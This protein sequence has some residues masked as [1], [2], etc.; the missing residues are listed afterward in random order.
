VTVRT[1]PSDPIEEALR[2]LTDR[3]PGGVLTRRSSL[4]AEARAGLQDASEA[5]RAAGLPERQAAERAVAEFGDPDALWADYAAQVEAGFVRRT[6]LLLGVGYLV[7]LFAWQITGQHA[8]DAMPRGS[9]AAS[10]SFG[11][12]GALAVLTMATAL[13]WLRARARRCDQAAGR[14]ARV[15][16]AAGLVCAVATLIAS[17]LVEPWGDRR[18]ADAASSVVHR[19]ELLVST[20]ELFSGALTFAIIWCSLN[21]LRLSRSVRAANRG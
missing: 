8:E 4:L 17:Y 12:I 3:L 16:G 1:A 20:V 7:I 9:V 11:Y 19:P 18:G 13:L 6:A 14:P 21:C 15:V 10:Y 2:Q 5:H